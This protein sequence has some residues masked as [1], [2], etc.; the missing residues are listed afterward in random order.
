[1]F[2]SRVALVVL[3]ADV[4]YE[5]GATPPPRTVAYGFVLPER[6]PG[7]AHP[8]TPRTQTLARIAVKWRPGT[9]V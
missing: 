4:V 5:F 9:C 1:M 7:E 2:A 6:A 3:F 8:G